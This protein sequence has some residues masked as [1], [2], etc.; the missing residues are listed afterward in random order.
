M[1]K[2]FLKFLLVIALFTFLAPSSAHAG[3]T[4]QQ[5]IDE[6]ELQVNSLK[7]DA[8]NFASILYAD[9]HYANCQ[10]RAGYVTLKQD[11]AWV[12]GPKL[13]DGYQCIQV[14]LGM[15]LSHQ[16]VELKA[17][18]KKLE[19]QLAGFTG[20]GDEFKWL[21][22]RVSSCEHANI[23]DSAGLRKLEARIKLLEEA[24]KP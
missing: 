3:K 9:N 15:G 12:R 22:N 7:L 8:V 24:D 23:D 1:T 18:V 11:Q 20:A 13:G 2:Y 6:L 10:R 5:R 14:P 4:K 16:V 21:E 19:D 17:K